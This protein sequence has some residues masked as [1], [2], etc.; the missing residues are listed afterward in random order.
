MLASVSSS[1]PSLFMIFYG[2]KYQAAETPHAWYAFHF[3]EDYMTGVLVYYLGLRMHPFITWQP[4][5]P[6]CEEVLA[7]LQPLGPSFFMQEV[8]LVGERKLDPLNKDERS[9]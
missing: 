9:S 5:H 2:R 4:P 6:T 7:L 8:G 3:N 1:L